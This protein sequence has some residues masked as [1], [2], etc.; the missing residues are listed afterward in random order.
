[1]ILLEGMLLVPPERGSIIG[2]AAWKVSPSSLPG[3]PLF[4][5]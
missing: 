5:K 4:K 2:R 3:E 1:M